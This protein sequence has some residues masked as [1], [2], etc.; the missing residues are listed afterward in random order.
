MRGFKFKLEGLL[1]LRKFAEQKVKLEIGEMV[2]Q[3][4]KSKDRIIQGDSRFECIKKFIMDKYLTT[5]HQI[6][7]FMHSWSIPHKP[8]NPSRHVRMTD[9]VML[10]T[11]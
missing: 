5:G 9:D 6:D 7:I 3:I 1:K 4:Q 8:E 11:Q 10:Y 2:S